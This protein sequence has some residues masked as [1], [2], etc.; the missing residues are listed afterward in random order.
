MN[1]DESRAALPDHEYLLL[2]ESGH[3]PRLEQPAEFD[4]ALLSFLGVE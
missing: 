3:T 1:A 4:A 2:D